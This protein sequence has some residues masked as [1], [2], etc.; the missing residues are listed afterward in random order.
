MWM[1]I[2]DYFLPCWRLFQGL[3]WNICQIKSGIL[4]R[5]RKEALLFWIGVDLG[6]GGT[7]VGFGCGQDHLQNQTNTVTVI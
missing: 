7:K 4:K 3:G 2:R 1:V 6:I 5:K